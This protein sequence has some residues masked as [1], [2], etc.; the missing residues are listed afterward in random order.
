MSHHDGPCLVVQVQEERCCEQVSAL[1][2]RCCCAEGKLRSRSPRTA[3][4]VEIGATV[5]DDSNNVHQMMLTSGLVLLRCGSSRCVRRSA[6]QCCE[7]IEWI[8]RLRR[9][10]LRIRLLLLRRTPI[11]RLCTREQLLKESPRWRH[12]Q[13]HLLPL[14]LGLHG[15]A[16]EPRQAED[17]PDD[18]AEEDQQQVP[19]HREE[20]FEHSE[21]QHGGQVSVVVTVGVRRKGTRGGISSAGR[22]ADSWRRNKHAN[23]RSK[24]HYP[25]NLRLHA[26]SLRLTTDS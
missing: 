26:C 15:D 1:L 18:A 21:A 14:L 7:R 12:R 13:W 23:K 16:I 22:R 8:Q 2:S 4:K 3:T 9:D 17:Q 24:L 6:L 25:N 10:H 11:G 19:V 5:Y 20:A